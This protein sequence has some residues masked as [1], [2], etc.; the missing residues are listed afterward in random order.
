MFRRIVGILLTILLAFGILFISVLRTAKVNYAFS[1]P[2][3]TPSQTDTQKEI[4]VDYQLPFPGGILPDS[5]LWGVKVLR[6]KVWYFITTSPLRRAELALLFADKRLVSSRLLFEGKKPDIAV[7]TFT[8]GEKYLEIAANQEK[9]ARAKGF[10]TSAFL[11]RLATAALKHREVAEAFL[12][13]V[14]EDGKPIVVK[15]EDYAKN[16]Y[17]ETRDALNSQGTAPPK[18]PFCGD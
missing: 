6:D 14:P 9:E 18:D 17:K 2:P 4:N 16:I 5:P 10:D 7:S 3:P 1:S 12:S 13:L 11:V 15:T 8:K